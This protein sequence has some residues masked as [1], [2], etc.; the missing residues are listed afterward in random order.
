VESR[1]AEREG[2]GPGRCVNDGKRNVIG[3]QIRGQ[4]S[5]RNN[6]R[7]GLGK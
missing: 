6:R 2:G 1:G 4:E 3:V 5:G 7:N